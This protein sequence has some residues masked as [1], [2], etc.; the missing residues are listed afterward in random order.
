MKD[1]SLPNDLTQFLRLGQQFAYDHSL[2][3]PGHV[4]L[5][6]A[7]DLCLRDFSV[8]TEGKE[9]A[10]RDPNRGTRG[11]YLVPAVD[12]AASCRAHSPKGILLW[13]PGEASFG[14]CDRDHY[15]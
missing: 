2:A 14:T 7:N 15:D 1:F 5:H 6:R 4:T 11:A 13:L 10:S 9:H 3:E 8:R 12:L